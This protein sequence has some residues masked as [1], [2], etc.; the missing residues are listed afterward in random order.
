MGIFNIS[1]DDPH[2]AATMSKALKD[3][4]PQLGQAGADTMMMAYEDIRSGKGLTKERERELNVSFMS[5]SKK[6]SQIVLILENIKQAIAD[7]VVGM[8]MMVIDGLKMIYNGMM[9]AYNSMMAINPLSSNKGEYEKL[10]GLY[11]NNME[12]NISARDKHWEATSESISKGM[13]QA[14]KYLSLT[15]ETDKQEK[16]NNVKIGL[17]KEEIKLKEPKPELGKFGQP[18][19][20]GEKTDDAVVDAIK[21]AGKY[22]FGNAKTPQ[23][24]K[25]FFQKPSTTDV[26]DGDERHEVKV[27]VT[28][29]GSGHETKHFK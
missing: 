15:I 27:V 26:V 14:K 23:S 9:Y 16:V 4:F 24:V 10:A 17:L 18:K 8:M 21:T 13:E 25:E 12:L 6:T 2:Y 7:T 1:R 29:Q 19:T 11:R 20:L 3:T 5:E 28:K 22:Y